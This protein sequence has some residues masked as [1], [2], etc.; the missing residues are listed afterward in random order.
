MDK[1][2][3][4]KI[5]G[6]EAKKFWTWEEASESL[7]DMFSQG[8]KRFQGVCRDINQEEMVDRHKARLRRVKAELESLEAQNGQ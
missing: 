4:I 8:V 3:I 2:W 6:Y 1:V 5:D 7:R